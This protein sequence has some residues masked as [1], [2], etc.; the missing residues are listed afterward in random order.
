M[1][2]IEIYLDVL[3]IWLI[4][5]VNESVWVIENLLYL[6]DKFFFW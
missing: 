2:M 5:F 4:G 1:I 3:Y 6:Y